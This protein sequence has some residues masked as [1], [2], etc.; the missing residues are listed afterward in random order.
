MPISNV[1][2]RGGKGI[3]HLTFNCSFKKDSKASFKNEFLLWS[4]L[5]LE[6]IVAPDVSFNA[7]TSTI[8]PTR[9][10]QLLDSKTEQFVLAEF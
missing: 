5:I 3:G 4:Q 8:S 6:R 1:L 9:T 2:G 10:V 7:C